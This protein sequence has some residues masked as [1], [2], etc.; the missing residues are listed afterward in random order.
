MGWQCLVRLVASLYML[1]NIII[2]IKY[3]LNLIKLEHGMLVKSAYNLLYIYTL[4]EVGK[5]NWVTHIKSILFRYVFF[6]SI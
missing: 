6:T 5:E 4:C 1:K 2:V 3:W